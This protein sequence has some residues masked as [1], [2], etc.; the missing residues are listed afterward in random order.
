MAIV[1]HFQSWSPISLSKMVYQPIL[2]WL[3]N[4]SPHKCP[5]ERPTK[6][7]YETFVMKVFKGILQDDQIHYRGHQTNVIM[8]LQFSIQVIKEAYEMFCQ[9]NILQKYGIICKSSREITRKNITPFQTLFQVQKY[10]IGP[11][12]HFYFIILSVSSR[13]VY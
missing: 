9:H 1:Y 2:T 6:V 8:N 13:H 4:F 10:D 5:P 7:L 3:V 11:N 12:I